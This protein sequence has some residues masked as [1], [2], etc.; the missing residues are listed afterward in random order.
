M[1]GHAARLHRHRK[2]LYQINRRI[3]FYVQNIMNSTN[4]EIKIPAAITS[5]PLAIGEKVVL[6]RI[7]T[8]PDSTNDELA[9]LLGITERGVKKI[10]HRLRSGGYIDQNGKGRARRLYL[11]FRVE[12]GTEFPNPEINAPAANG[13]L[14]APHS[15]T[16]VSEDAVGTALQ[17]ELSLA[18][19]YDQTMNVIAE[20]SLQP[21]I[22]PETFVHLLD[23]LIQRSESEMQSSPA[24][25]RLL[26]DLYTRRNGFF[27]IAMASRLPKEF[28]SELRQKISRA[29]PEQLANIHDR[30]RAKQ[31]DQRTPHLL[32]AWANEVEVKAR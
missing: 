3:L 26:G 10:L 25:E 27:A 30:C 15:Q 2:R 31:L 12:Q 13:E 17:V 24:K 20:M 14:R 11:T 32:A 7:A 23:K 29:T 28:H 8:N 5:L 18:D 9:K 4:I 16:P 21:G 6:T 22:F 1:D 19:E